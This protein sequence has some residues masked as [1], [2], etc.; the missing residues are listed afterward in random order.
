MNEEYVLLGGLWWKW[1]GIPVF[2]WRNH[3]AGSWKT[4]LAGRLSKKVF[5]TSQSSYTASFARAVQ[6]PVGV[7]AVRFER[8]TAVRVPR[9]I[10]FLGRLSP[11]KRPHVLLDALELLEKNGIEYTASLYGPHRESDTQYVEELR[12]RAQAS[13]GNVRVYGPVAHEHLGAIYATHDIFV[14]LSDPG[15]YDKTLFEAALSG[16]VV[17]ATSPDFN[18]LHGVSGLAVEPVAQTL[19]EALQAQLRASEAERM[20]VQQK[21]QSCAKTQ[22]LAILA[23]RIVAEIA[24]P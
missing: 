24:T 14:N 19:S 2:M 22:S 9:S 18:A 10:L 17:L 4:R 15:M 12:R 13:Q 11:S 1:L 21:L 16:C 7:D 8:A 6:M 3:Y 23:E 20:A 5:Y